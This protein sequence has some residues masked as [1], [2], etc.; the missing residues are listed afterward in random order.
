VITDPV[1]KRVIA[2]IRLA[3]PYTGLILTTRE[4]AEIRRDLLR[5]GISQ[6]SAGSRTYP[7]AYADTLTN[8]PEAQQ[9]WVGDARSLPEIIQD[10]Q[11]MGFMPSFCTACY[12]LGRTGEAFMGLAKSAFIHTF[13]E[14][15]ALTSYAEYL[16]DYATPELRASGRRF[17][18]AR[19]AA[20]Q[21]EGIRAAVQ[22]RLAAIDAGTRDVYL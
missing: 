7:G 11:N 20:I 4:N 14:P 6:M 16:A 9:F 15:N 10:L 1:F 13:C 22:E 19:A 17:V 12:R 2:V 8:R 21:E 5:A 3:M 18:D